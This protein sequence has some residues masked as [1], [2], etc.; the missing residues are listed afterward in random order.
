MLDKKIFVAFNP[1]LHKELDEEFDSRRGRALP[2]K[3]NVVDRASPL[4]L[5]VVARLSPQTSASPFSVGREY[6]IL[7]LLPPSGMSL[8]ANQAL[9]ELLS[10]SRV[11]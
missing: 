11:C 6:E 10:T 1:S 5:I 3:P 7:L 2:C 9:P 4:E 8:V